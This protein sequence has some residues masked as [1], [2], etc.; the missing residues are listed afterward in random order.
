MQREQEQ[1]QLLFLAYWSAIYNGIRPAFKDGSNPI[2]ESF[3][4]GQQKRQM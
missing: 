4:P 3:T 2:P 1:R